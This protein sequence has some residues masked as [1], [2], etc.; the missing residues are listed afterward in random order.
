V[1]SRR[2]TVTLIAPAAQPVAPPPVSL[3]SPRQLAGIPD[4]NAAAPRVFLSLAGS[5]GLGN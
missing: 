2:F 5:G 1:Q 4:A 3:Q